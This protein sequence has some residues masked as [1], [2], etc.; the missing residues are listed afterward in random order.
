[1]VRSLLC[2]NPC[3]SYLD[4]VSLSSVKASW[5]AAATFNQTG[6]QASLF[7]NNVIH[8]SRGRGLSFLEAGNVTARGNI[9][10]HTR[11]HGIFL[12]GSSALNTVEGNLIVG[13][14]VNSLQNATDM[15]P[16][17]IYATN[18]QNSFRYEWKQLHMNQ[19]PKPCTEYTVVTYRLNCP[20]QRHAAHWN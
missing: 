9:V 4:E 18:W 5:R 2:L 14:R 13:A 20:F 12:N 16:A 11:G 10:S 7:Q 6:S 15:Q 8:R 3:R 1:M 19:D 17:G